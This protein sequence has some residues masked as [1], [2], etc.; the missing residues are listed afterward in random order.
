MKKPWVVLGDL[1]GI[2]IQLYDRVH[3][4]TINGDY[5]IQYTIQ[6]YGDYNTPLYGPLLNNQYNEWNVFFSRGSSD[7]SPTKFLVTFLV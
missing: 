7:V 6:L 2:T 4:F 3:N 5:M 1:L